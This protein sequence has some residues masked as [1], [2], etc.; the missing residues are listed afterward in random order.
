[1]DSVAWLMGPCQLHPAV[2]V[3]QFKSEQFILATQG[4]NQVEFNYRG[5]SYV[6]Q[7]IELSRVWKEPRRMGLGKHVCDVVLG[8]SIWRSNRVKD[9]VLPLIDDM[10]QPTNILPKRMPTEAKILRLKFEVERKVTN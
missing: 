1:M 3:R 8:Y 6:N 10:V 5:L 2:S 9:I 7:V 4:F